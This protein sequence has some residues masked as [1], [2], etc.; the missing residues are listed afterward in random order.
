MKSSEKLWG[1]GS[2]STLRVVHT[3]IVTRQFQVHF[4]S[5]SLRQVIHSPLPCQSGGIA[6]VSPRVR[7]VP[8]RQQQ[9]PSRN[10]VNR[11]PYIFTPHLFQHS[12]RV[13]RHAVH[14]I[15]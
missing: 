9:A 3:Q 13:R 12:P 5:N 4:L 10:Q 8:L 7:Q 6:I 14:Q 11:G 15:K 1:T 2:A